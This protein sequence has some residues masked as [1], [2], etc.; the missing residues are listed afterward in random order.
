MNLSLRRSTALNLNYKPLKRT[1]VKTSFINN[2]NVMIF[3]SLTD[4]CGVS[5]VTHSILHFGLITP[6]R[7]GLL[8]LPRG[9]ECV[10]LLLC[11]FI[12]NR[13]V[14]QYSWTSWAAAA[15]FSPCVSY[16]KPSSRHLDVLIHDDISYLQT[17]WVMAWFG[18]SW[19]CSSFIYSIRRMLAVI[20]RGCC[21]GLRCERWEVMRPESVREF[22]DRG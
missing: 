14:V 19:G 1:N 18:V 3:S 20:V 16:M 21:W 12:H 8:S 17:W 10:P 13:S 7:H 22:R 15:V 9:L 6:P 5:G 2:R 4:G 11:K